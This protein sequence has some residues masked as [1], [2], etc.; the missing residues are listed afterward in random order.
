MKGKKFGRGSYAELAA[1]ISLGLAAGLFGLAP[2]AAAAPV[3][4]ASSNLNTVA[5]DAVKAAENAAGGVTTRVNGTETNN[6][7]AWKDFSVGKNDVV[8]FDNGG[9]VHNYLNVV[10][11]QATSHIAG[12][13]EGGKDVYIVNQHGVI[14]DE[15]SQ[16]NVGNLY[17]S[18][19]DIESVVNQM[20]SSKTGAEVI[21]TQAVMPMKDVVNLGTVTANEVVVVG[22]NVTFRNA[23]DV[24]NATK[25]QMATSNGKIAVGTETGQADDR[26]VSTDMAKRRRR[27]S[28]RSSLSKMP[29]ISKTS[30]K[31]R[32][33]SQES[34]CSQVTLT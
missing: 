34:I 19:G 32:F 7:V 6:V 17:V 1:K 3:H 10:T 20:T 13:I 22:A 12:K 4:D 21:S 9:Q 14:F 33:R 23:A 15:G 27:G 18:T 11:T 28:T 25:V 2:N 16:V 29:M 24:K 30:G 5:A 31:M 26:F 8:Q